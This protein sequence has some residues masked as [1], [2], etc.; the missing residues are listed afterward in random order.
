MGTGQP[1]Y[2]DDILLP[3]PKR[4]LLHDADWTMQ[5]T[6][7]PEHV[8]SAPEVLE[9]LKAMYPGNQWELRPFYA[10]ILKHDPTSYI[11]I[12]WQEEDGCSIWYK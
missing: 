11:C 7:R 2:D 4:I 6:F 9:R 10:A 3:G 8:P 12:K 1:R 5:S